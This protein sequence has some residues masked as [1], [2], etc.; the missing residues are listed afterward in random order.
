MKIKY[1]WRHANKSL[2]EVIIASFIRI[3]N[4][5]WDTVNVSN[6]VVLVV[7]LLDLIY[8]LVSCH[9]STSEIIMEAFISSCAGFFGY[10]DSFCHMHHPF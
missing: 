10:S 5:S 9:I 2:T 1:G 6:M 3:R 7:A 4:W 8:E